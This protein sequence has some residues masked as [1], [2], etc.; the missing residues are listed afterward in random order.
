MPPAGA[1]AASRFTLLESK[2]RVPRPRAGAVQRSSLTNRL[3]TGRRPPI[4]VVEGA[5]GSGKTTLAADW[6]QRDRRPFA[7]YSIDETDDDPTVF[8]TY[9]AVALGRCGAA[10]DRARQ[11]L[12]SQRGTTE[13][14]ANALARALASMPAPA[15]LVLDQLD[16]LANPECLGALAAL[17]DEVPAGSQ[18]VLLTRAG[19]DLPLADARTAGRVLDLA[20]DDLRLSDAEAGAL[21]RAAG[22]E[23]EPDDVRTL[24]ARCEGWATGLYLVALAG[25]SAFERLRDGADGGIDRFVGDFLRLEVLDRLDDVDREVLL[26]ASV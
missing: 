17:L 8:L 3:R 21:V 13:T 18:L 23:L 6:A 10:V 5:A 15:V 1:V 2:L 22:L 19:L 11:R 12:A 24:N 26:Q 14:V 7:W 9:L 4:V 16:A 25:D 20:A